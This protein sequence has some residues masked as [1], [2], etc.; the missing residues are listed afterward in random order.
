MRIQDFADTRRAGAV[1]RY[2]TV[3]TIGEQTLATH[4]WGTAMILA[5]ILPGAS[6]EALMAALVHDVPEWKYGD[7]PSPAKR[8]SADLRKVMEAAEQEELARLSLQQNLVE[9]EEDALKQADL[10][11]LLW[12]CLEQRRLGNT[13]MNE[14]FARGVEYTNGLPLLPRAQEMLSYIIS[15]YGRT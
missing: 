6:R 7:T 3:S 8:L 15:E 10:L 14:I 1:K 12:Y 2:H 13:N 11:E 5:Y 4:Q 9:K